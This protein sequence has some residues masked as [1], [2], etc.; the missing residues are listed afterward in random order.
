MHRL[1]YYFF[2]PVGLCL[3]YSLDPLMIPWKFDEPK[4]LLKA[5]D[6]NLQGQLAD[7]GLIGSRGII[8]GAVPTIF[9]QLLLL[10]TQ[11]LFILNLIKIVLFVL[12]T[13]FTFLYCLQECKLSKIYVVIPFLS[14]FLYHF[15]RILWDNIFLIPLS[16]V[17]FAIYLK[18]LKNNRKESFIPLIFFVL[19]TTLLFQTHLMSLMIIL[20]LG[21]MLFYFKFD[22]FR[23]HK[24]K[25][26]LILSLLV[27]LNLDYAVY[28]CTAY[29][30]LAAEGKQLEF[31][32]I[33]NFIFPAHIAGYQWFLQYLTLDK[34]REIN[35]LNYLK[36]AT[37]LIPVLFYVPLLLLLKKYL[38]KK[39]RENSGG[40]DQELRIYLTIAVVFV[41]S[42]FF[43][44]IF[45]LDNQPHYLNSL[46]VYIFL[47]IIIGIDY[48]WKNTVVRYLLI[49]NII[50][51]LMSSLCL[52]SFLIG[53]A[54]T[55]TV[56]FGP[57]LAEQL[58]I[59]RQTYSSVS[60]QLVIKSEIP[61][62]HYFKLAIP[63]LFKLEKI[64]N[65]DDDRLQAIIRIEYSDQPPGA[66]LTATL[67]T[68]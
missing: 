59:A 40:E 13:Y 25:T 52:N 19:L 26:I 54:G 65:S 42:I 15:S 64:R 17:L 37:Y 31:S 49:L 3:L 1:V 44:L 66:G 46:Y 57:S 20:P 47:G 56:L 23:L 6:A 29:L 9:Y 16:T 53:N 2:L 8:Y 4:L 43:S 12:T 32:G 34:I 35:F 55:R 14:P 50:A 58:K 22:F 67:E 11:D 48:F 41:F 45:K 33:F 24:V 21:G 30:D 39:V 18:I 36:Y 7:Y 5:L 38:T 27:L 10:I 28:L 63:A 60:N 61:H 51:L 62:F 68:K